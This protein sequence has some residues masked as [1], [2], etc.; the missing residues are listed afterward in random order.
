MIGIYKI[1]MRLFISYSR[2]DKNYVY[3]FSDALH[4]ETRHEVWIDKRLVGADR[5]WDTILHEI[6]AC[7]CFVTVLT[8]RCVNSIYCSAE[9][10]YALALQQPILPL[11]L[12]PCDGIMPSALQ[13]IQFI[14]IE[15][16][17]LEKAVLRAAIALGRVELGIAQGHYSKL[18]T[19]PSRPPVP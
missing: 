9:L 5:W 1:V 3:E 11:L 10:D 17:T 14:D 8:P 6:E 12:K 18:K 16:V 7:D 13:P 2:D 4:D 15:T 19:K